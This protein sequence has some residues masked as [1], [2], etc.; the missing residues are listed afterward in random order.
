VEL[1]V[2]TLA[3]ILAEPEEPPHRLPVVNRAPRERMSGRKWHLI[4]ERD[5]G[6]CW[7]CGAYVPKGTGEVDHV[8]PRSSF[9]EADLVIADR[10]DNL[11]TTCVPCNQQKSNYVY[12]WAPNVVGVT[13]KCWECSN[14]GVQYDGVMQTNA[15]CGH[16]GY[17]WV[18]DDGWL[19]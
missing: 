14:P 8:Q 17:T 2:K 5:G 18:P 6:K 19:M 16:C 12:D 9:Q 3:E 10:S 11:K 1:I 7:I 4:H 13:D 15:Y